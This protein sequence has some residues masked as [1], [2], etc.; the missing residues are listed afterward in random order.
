MI[1]KKLHFIWIGDETKCPHNCIQT[2]QDKNPDYEIKIWGNQELINYGWVLSDWMQ[3]MAKHH[4]SGIADL[5]RYEILYREGGITLDADSICLN[6]LEDWLLQTNEFAAW[7]NEHTHSGTIAN[8]TMGSTRNSP[9]FAQ[10]IKYFMDKEVLIDDL[11]FKVTGPAA[12]TKIWQKT[13]YPLTIYPS[14][15]FY[16]IHWTGLKYKGNGKVFATQLWGTT[17]NIYQSLHHSNLQD[18]LRENQESNED[19]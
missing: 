13:T 18:L 5:M 19:A 12:L 8:G 3:E 7:E 16:P 2:W 11:P 10:I 1:E 4:P 9:F 15:Y 14:H 6:P 17:K